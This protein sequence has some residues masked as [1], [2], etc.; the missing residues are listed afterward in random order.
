MLGFG[1]LLI[2]KGIKHTI[3]Y[4]L[5]ISHEIHFTCPS[6]GETIDYSYNKA[7]NMTVMG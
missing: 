1:H 7:K 2:Y 6:C 4:E 3:D 5:R